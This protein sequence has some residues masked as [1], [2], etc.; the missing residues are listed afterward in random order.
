MAIW[1]HLS[2]LDDLCEYTDSLGRSVC[3]MHDLHR[4]GPDWG[5]LPLTL[6]MYLLLKKAH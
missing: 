4:E 5:S 6:P 1:S 2:N 3:H